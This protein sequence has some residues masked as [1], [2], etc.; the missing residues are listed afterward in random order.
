MPNTMDMLGPNIR[1]DRFPS[2]LQAMIMQ[3]GPPQQDPRLQQEI[4]QADAPLEEESV[5][6]PKGIAKVIAE[7]L[8]KFSQ[9]GAQISPR[10]EPPPG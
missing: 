6:I 9:A 8:M 7:L 5:S 2:E 1:Q 4:Q 3:Q 10:L